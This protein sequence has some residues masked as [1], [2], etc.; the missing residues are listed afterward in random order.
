MNRKFALTIILV[1]ILAISIVVVLTT[2]TP[3]N[4]SAVENV[5][6]GAYYYIWWGIPFNNHWDHGVK[7]TPFLGKYNSSDPLIADRHILL[8]KQHKIDFF[9][10]SWIGKG[11]WIPPWDFDDIDQNLQSGF[12]QAPRLPSFSFCLFYETKLVLDTANQAHKNFTEIFINDMVYA[13]QQYFNHSSYLRVDGKP[14]LFIYDLPYLYENLS[15]PQAQ[16]LFDTLRQQLVGLHV[17]VYLVGDVGNQYYPPYLYSMDA[18][19]SYFFSDVSKGWQQ[20]L[21]DANHYYPIWRSDMNS[22]GIKFIPDA[23]PGFDNTE[24][25]KWENRSSEAKTLPLDEIKFKEMLT[26]AINYSDNSLKTV[27]ITSWNEWMESTT[28]EPSM[29]FGELFLHTI[30]DVIP[31]FLSFLIL[32]LFIIATLMAAIVYGKKKFKILMK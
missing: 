27:M 11:D 15:T 9:T 7:Y 10:V 23:Y 25:C 24:H 21:E 4:V 3:I 2:K 32:P 30:Y 17:N 18:V 31:E 20:I 29:E 8:A 19:T 13:S 14:V 12:L 5:K 28:I 16:T 26:T 22:R 1:A 6:I